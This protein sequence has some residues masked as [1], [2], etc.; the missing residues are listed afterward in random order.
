MPCVRQRWCCFHFFSRPHNCILAQRI[1]HIIWSLYILHSV[2]ISL[3]PVPSILISILYLYPA[4]VYWICILHLYHASVSCIC[5]LYHV[6]FIQ[7]SGS[8]ILN[9]P[10]SLYPSIDPM[11]QSPINESRHFHFPRPCLLYTSPSPRD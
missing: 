4:T 6:S 10:C 8:F 3:T 1:M 9:R 5:I 11:P 7:F 2:T